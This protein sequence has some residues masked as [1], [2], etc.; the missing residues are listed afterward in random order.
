M[1]PPICKSLPLAAITRLLEA[2]DVFGRKQ[3]AMP[4]A[5]SKREGLWKPGTR[6]PRG[7]PGWSWHG[8]PPEEAP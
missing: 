5:F 1:Y 4:W 8:A 6:G 3:T 2:W 7:L